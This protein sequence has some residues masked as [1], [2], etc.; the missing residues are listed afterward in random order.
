[1]TEKPKPA[2][3]GRPQLMLVALVFI[4]PMAAALLLYFGSDALRPGGTSNHGALL[5]PIVNLRDALPGSEFGESID[6]YWALIYRNTGACGEDC[7]GALYKLRQS[8]LMLG[9][10]MNRVERVFL[11]GT[12]APD[13][14]FL[15]SEHGGMTTLHAPDEAALL[16]S[17]RPGDQPDGGYYLLDPLGNIVM[18]F[19][20]GIVPRDMVDDVS[21]LLDLS[22]IG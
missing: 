6:G 7:R 14:V 1:M 17:V 13:R 4:V 12:S 16:E 11:H 9:N 19:P 5:A 22:R 8:R 20:P 2:R 18:Y 3:S 10:E 15:D 21:H